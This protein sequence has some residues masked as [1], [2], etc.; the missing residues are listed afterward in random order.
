MFQPA[1]V[2]QLPERERLHARH[3]VQVPHRAGASEDD[4]SSTNIRR[5]RA[6][7]TIRCRAPENAELYREVP[8]AGATQTPDV[9]FV[10]RLATYK[11]YNM[12]QVVAQAL[13][14]YKKLS[15]ARRPQ[16]VAQTA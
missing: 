16:V 10:G 6:I 3:R 13:T 11:Y 4:A 12:D 5:R 2:D 8:G 1:P 14:L 7:R 15:G 9:H